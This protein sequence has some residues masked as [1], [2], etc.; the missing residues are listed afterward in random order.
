M[1][2]IN[3]HEA[4]ERLGSLLDAVA[5]GEEVMILRHG[6]PGACK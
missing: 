6:K 5:S 3:V 4:Q 2:T 1:Q